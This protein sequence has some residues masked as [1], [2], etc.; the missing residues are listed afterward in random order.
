MKALLEMAWVI[1]KLN[2]SNASNK[3]LEIQHHY[4]LIELYHNKFMMYIIVYYSV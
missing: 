2:T 1:F 4:E 3:V